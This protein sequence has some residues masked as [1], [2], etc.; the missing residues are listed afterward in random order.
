MLPGKEGGISGFQMS[1]SQNFATLNCR[2]VRMSPACKR[3]HAQKSGQAQ[4]SPR[5]MSPAC[6]SRHVRVSPACKHRHIQMSP[7]SNVASVLNM[8][9]VPESR[10]AKFRHARNFGMT[11]FVRGDILRVATFWGWRH[12]ERGDIL[13]SVIL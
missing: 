13:S 3:Q 12:F 2:H 5:S 10:Q 1:P 6:K 9:P 11:T 4:I 8:S 7:R